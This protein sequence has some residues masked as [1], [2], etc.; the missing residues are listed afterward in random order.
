MPP[1]GEPVRG[2]EC[3]VTPVLPAL[4]KVEGSEVEGLTLTRPTI[5]RGNDRCLNAEASV[6]R[7]AGPFQ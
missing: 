6:L 7:H 5:S 4:S 1:L 2:R 3:R